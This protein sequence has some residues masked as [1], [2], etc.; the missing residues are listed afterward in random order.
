MLSFNMLSVDSETD[1][2]L[3]VSCLGAAGFMELIIEM[4]LKEVHK[5]RVVKP[6]LFVYC[7]PEYLGFEF[8]AF[9]GVKLEGFDY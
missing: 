6:L 8:V 9:L 1:G 2:A 3:N 4:E 5:T 7:A